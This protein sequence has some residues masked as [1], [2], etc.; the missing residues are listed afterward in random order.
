LTKDVP[1]W[2]QLDIAIEKE[3]IVSSFGFYLDFFKLSENIFACILAETEKKDLES[4]IHV[5]ILRGYIKMAMNFA[6]TKKDYNPSSILN[7]INFATAEDLM[8]EEFLVNLIVMNLDNDQILYSNSLKCDAY[9]VD[10]TSHKL[11]NI[12]INNQKLGSDD[13]ATFVET[14]LNFNVSDRIILLSKKVHPQKQEILKKIILDNMLF[15][16]LHQA[17]KILNGFKNFIIKKENEIS[18]VI[19][20][21]RKA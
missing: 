15:S 7:M 10:N 12:I 5:S 20:I 2:K 11:T 1:N 13:S 16:C 6:K 4:F 3:L 21:E 18:S 8:N 14:T 9:Y 17:E 19:C